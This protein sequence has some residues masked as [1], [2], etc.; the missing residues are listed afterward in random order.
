MN[1][2]TGDGGNDR[3]SAVDVVGGLG[4]A[5]ATVGERGADNKRWLQP[6]EDR[7]SFPVVRS[8]PERGERGPLRA[9]RSAEGGSPRARRTRESRRVSLAQ[10]AGYVQLNQYRLLEPI[11]QGSYGIV[12]LAYSEEDDTH[13]AM[14][15]LSKR[16]L[17]RRAGLFG[18]TPPRR[19]GTQTAATN[20]PQP[21]A[22]PL[23]RVYREIAVLKKLD[24]PNVVKLV[25][26]LD[27]PAED[28][29]YLVFA[30]LEGG[31]V[32][33]V[34]T[35]RPL[36]EDCARTYFRDALLG[37]EYLHYQRIAH[38]DIKPANLLLGDGRVQLADLGASGELAGEVR[39]AG[40]VGTP[41][42]RAPE[43]AVSADTYLGEAADIWSLGATLYAMVTGRVP[44]LASSV[45]E[46]QRRILADPLTFPAR[47]H[48]SRPL[49]RLLFRMLDKDPNTRAT[50]KEIKNHEWVTN[51]GTEP[52]PSEEENCRLVEVT[53]EDMAQVVTSIP[54]LS[55]LI[56]IKTMLKKHS[57]QNPF[58]RSRENSAR[59]ESVDSTGEPAARAQRKPGLARSG[60]SLSAP[61]NYMTEKQQSFE[62]A[63]EAVEER[64]AQCG[65]S[66]E[67][68]NEE[69]AKR[70]KRDDHNDTNQTAK[71]N[72]AQKVASSQSKEKCQN[73]EGSSR[74]ISSTQNSNDSQ[75]SKISSCSNRA[76]RCNST[77]DRNCVSSIGNGQS[78]VRKN[79]REESKEKNRTDTVNKG[80]DA[81]VSR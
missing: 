58:L 64:D 28:Q 60:R 69:E 24:H 61:G 79:S 17:M 81:K 21:T 48:L 67:E 56:L 30:L 71:L 36:P 75:S 39:L 51:N 40:A 1:G 72:T 57:F 77:K 10:A 16:K 62:T 7:V 63:L 50:M 34:P 22:D 65:A 9:A 23:Q 6:A 32:V 47:P 27:D 18:K 70:E 54:N 55:T 15:I 38:R 45:A 49:K 68:S 66:E 4:A 37:V 31:P 41:A 78:K 13:Y 19:P 11:G 20:A 42:F 52:L 43:A 5:E 46:L 8:E 3:H 25:E 26:V 59:R 44:W 76:E 29:L 12:K 35:D 53:D 80:K 2:V 74:K 14:K 33:D 73:G